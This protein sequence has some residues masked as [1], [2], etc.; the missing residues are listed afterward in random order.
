MAQEEETP[1]VGDIKKGTSHDKR[2]MTLMNKL[3]QFNVS[4]Q[5]F[6]VQNIVLIKSSLA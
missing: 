6:L 3:Q 5:A 4:I 1:V 2:E